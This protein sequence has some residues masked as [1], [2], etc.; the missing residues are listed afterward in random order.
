MF[1]TITP[2]Q[3][4]ISSRAV[5]EYV[6]VLEENHLATHDFIMARGNNILAECYYAPFHKDFKH[7]MYSVSK[8]FVSVAIGLLEEDGKLSLDDKVIDYFPEFAENEY[9]TDFM[10]EQTIRDM[11]KMTTSHS[12][13]INWF[14]SG[15]KDRRECYFQSVSQWNSGTIWNYD[16]PGSYTMGCIVEKLTGQP[17]LEFLKDRFLRK[18]GFGEDTYC[19]QAPGG[20]SFSDSGVMCTARDL[21]IFARFVANHGTWDGVRYM[22]EDYLKTATSYLADNSTSGFV[23]AADYGYGYQ[24]WQAPRGGFA[25]IGMGDQFAIY[26]PKTDFL[27]ITNGD[28]QGNNYSPII[29]YSFLYKLIVEKL[30]QP[31]PEDPEAYRELTDYLAS[32]KLYHYP[33]CT[34]SPCAERISGVTYAM[35]ENKMGIKTVRF[36]FD[37]DKGT[38]TYENEQGVK[39]ITFG[40]G[41]NEFQKFPQEGYADLIATVPV[42]GHMYESAISAAWTEENKL[43]IKVQI[44]DKYFGVLDMAFGFK[45]DAV[46]VQMVKTAEAFLDE[47]SGIA[48]GKAVK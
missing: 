7:R 12:G 4:G 24:I 36:D 35:D 3:A 2:E 14:Y 32:R 26:D 30:D 27:F 39:T 29:I 22:N 16:S 23:S 8:S 17:F 45:G 40:F 18:C 44:I 37:G 21:L 46:S 33:G 11:L 42:P 43:H 25:F 47:Y 31:L 28:N 19:I 15:T 10:R 6:K 5:L 13:G 20:Y 41:H 38:M 34:T 9:L 1:K 48:N